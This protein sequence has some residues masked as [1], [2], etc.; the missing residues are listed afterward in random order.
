M[1][2]KIVVHLANNCSL[3]QNWHGSSVC[4]Q[5]NQRQVLVNTRV[6]YLG[7]LT[8]ALNKTPSTRLFLSNLLEVIHSQLTNSKYLGQD[9]FKAANPRQWSE[10]G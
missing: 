3:F 7:V 1:I 9:A 4:F 5:L 10:S 8:L 6:L 2:L